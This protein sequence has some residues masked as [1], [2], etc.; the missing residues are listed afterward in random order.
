MYKTI[1]MILALLVATL[2]A[3]VWADYVSEGCRNKPR[4][5]GN[6]MAL[7][8]AEVEK[9]YEDDE[10]VFC[11]GVNWETATPEDVRGIDPNAL[12]FW[13]EPPL[14]YA[15][16]ADNIPAIIA[17]LQAGA[18]AD[19]RKLGRATNNLFYSDAMLY[20]PYKLMA[21]IELGALD[22][23]LL[24]GEEQLPA[25]SYS[26][27]RFMWGNYDDDGRD[28][29][30]NDRALRHKQI[31]SLLS[32]AT[33]RDVNE[34]INDA[35]KE[36]IRATED[37]DHKTN[38]E[39]NVADVRPTPDEAKRIAAELKQEFYEKY[40]H[41]LPEGAT[42]KFYEKYGHLLAEGAAGQNQAS[43]T[44]AEK[45]PSCRYPDQGRRFADSELIELDAVSRT[46]DKVYQSGECVYGSGMAADAAEC[47][48]ETKI[49]EGEFLYTPGAKCKKSVGD[50]SVCTTTNYASDKYR[51]GIKYHNGY[52][53][54]LSDSSPV[55]KVKDPAK[56]YNDRFAACFEPYKLMLTK[57]VDKDEYKCIGDPQNE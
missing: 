33:G 30:D 37:D 4:T 51:C 56:G 29:D 44:S 15:A 31:L 11:F 2:S 50:I 18:N 39:R 49:W 23:S 24:R 54:S 22:L 27:H 41:L 1:L 46:K 5:Y 34:V 36:A 9:C 53:S 7:L 21:L 26:I 20:D 42:E 6:C 25:I 12:S 52:Y 55:I 28:S 47:V 17:L 43:E 8:D 10:R 57:G 35:L 32:D 40:G 3:P 48:V 38:M 13:R 14:Y 45:H 19:M 16:Y